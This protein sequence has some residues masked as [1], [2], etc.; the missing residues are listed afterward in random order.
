MVSSI[1]IKN[2]FDF[3]TK[4]QICKHMCTNTLK[5]VK[6]KNKRIKEKDKVCLI[7][8]VTALIFSKSVLTFLIIIW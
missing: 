7:M 3:P 2:I 8:S 4:N 1:V 5:R 6:E